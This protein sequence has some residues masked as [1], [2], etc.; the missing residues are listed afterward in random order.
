MP[1]APDRQ[2]LDFGGLYDRKELFW[3]TIQDVVVCAACAPP[4][5]GR[6]QLNGRFLRHFCMLLI[7]QPN[8]NTLVHIFRV[9]DD[10]VA[11]V[12]PALFWLSSTRN[13]QK[14]RS[15]RRVEISSL[16]LTTFQY[17]AQTC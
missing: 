1:V 3:K 4:G 15:S 17:S 2:L 13:S 12:H 14:E 11:R 8:E 7:P 9:G 5:G 16:K 10:G 6:H